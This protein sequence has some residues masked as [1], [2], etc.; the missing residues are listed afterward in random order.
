LCRYINGPASL[1]R[2][3]RTRVRTRERKKTLEDV[4]DEWRDEEEEP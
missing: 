1:C 4:V 2:R 3:S